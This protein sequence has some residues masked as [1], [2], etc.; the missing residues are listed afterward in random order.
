MREIKFRA[1]DKK[2]KKMLN[3]KDLFGIGLQWLI[4]PQNTNQIFM[5]FTGLKDK[6]GKEIYEGDIVKYLSYTEHKEYKAEVYFRSGCFLVNKSGLFLSLISMPQ[7]EINLELM[8][9]EY[10]KDRE[11]RYLCEIIGNIYENPELLKE[12][13]TQEKGDLEKC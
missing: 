10:Y 11:Y 5:Q 12:F 6:N 8:N 13:G 4:S 1:W 7:K 2:E 3:E 9:T